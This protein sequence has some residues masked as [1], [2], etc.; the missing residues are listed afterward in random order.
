MQRTAFVV[1]VPPERR[2][3]G[4]ITDQLL[5]GGGIQ[6]TERRTERGEW[7][8]RLGSAFDCEQPF[9]Q[10][11]IRRAARTVH[12]RLAQGHMGS[13]EF[14]LEG[15]DMT[16]QPAAFDLQER[17]L[18]GGAARLVQLFAQGL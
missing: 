3:R 10:V 5:D 16:C 17:G 18:A 12:R 4:D 13:V 6:R 7:H 15:F 9:Q 14:R 2:Q 1:C 11:A 8:G